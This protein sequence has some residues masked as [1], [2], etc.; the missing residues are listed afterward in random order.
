MPNKKPI[1]A[2]IGMIFVDAKKR[3]F[4]QIKR[5]RPHKDV[6]KVGVYASAFN[7]MD[8]KCTRG[9]PRWFPLKEL[10]ESCRLVVNEKDLGLPW[11]IL[12]RVDREFK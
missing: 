2:K 11:R 5:L 9:K 1:D 3:L 10:H 6:D 8:G 4:Y 12:E 7:P